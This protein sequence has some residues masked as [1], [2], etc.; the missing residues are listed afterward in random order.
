MRRLFVSPERLGDAQLV[1]DGDAHQHLGR[2]LRAR[3]GDTLVVFDGQGNE[4]NAEVIET[5]RERTTLRVGA[6]RPALPPPV[7]V[8]LLQ[9]MAR[10]E[11]M[12][13]IVQKTCELGVARIV[14]VLTSRVVP[15]GPA[16]SPRRARW[17]KIAQEAARQSGRA[18]VPAV[19]EA[20]S[21][22]DAVAAADPQDLRLL[23]WEQSRGQPL[24][25]ALPPS[26]RATTLLVGPEGGFAEEEVAAAEAAGFTAVT[27]G[28]RILRVETAA[29]VAVTLVQASAGGLD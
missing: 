12:D 21:L 13:W 3:P 2:V 25:L 24:R 4:W 7:R 15:R 26:P 14:P 8:T 22:A 1:L 10:G 17:Q 18:D 20:V 19:D 28:P 23:L 6:R 9:A 27:L 16:S 29:I 5:G 11:R